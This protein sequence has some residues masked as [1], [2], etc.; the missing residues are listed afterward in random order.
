MSYDE[1]GG[2]HRSA[3]EVAHFMDLNDAR[4]EPTQMEIQPSSGESLAEGA[5]QGALSGGIVGGVIGV[6]G[7]ILMPGVSPTIAEGLLGSALAAAGLGAAVGGVIGTLIRAED[8]AREARAI[9]VPEPG[10]NDFWEGQDRRGRMS[11]NYGGPERRFSF[12]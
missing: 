12:S 1:S 7:S 6:L 3:V 5:G 4:Q 10:A 11:F 8:R 2:A 9:A